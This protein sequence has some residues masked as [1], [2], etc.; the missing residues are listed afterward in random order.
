[1]SLW[2]QVLGET[3]AFAVRA[4]R[5]VRF[6]VLYDSG[7]TCVE[8][9]NGPDAKRRSLHTQRRLTVHFAT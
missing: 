8:L 4:H 5:Q 7:A 3:N 6:C 1:M 9:H 2:L